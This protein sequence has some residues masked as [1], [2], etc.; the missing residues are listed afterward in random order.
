[1][2]QNV[3]KHTSF[4]NDAQVRNVG[5]NALLAYLMLRLQRDTVFTLLGN[6]DCFLIMPTGG[7]KSLCFQLPSLIFPGITLVVSPLIGAILFVCKQLVLN[8]D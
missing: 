2:L 6:N 3:F 1:M 8:Y 4:R 5:L 7:G